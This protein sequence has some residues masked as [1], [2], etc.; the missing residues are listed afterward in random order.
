MRVDLG[1]DRWADFRDPET[2][3]NRERYQF[4]KKRIP[5]AIDTVARSSGVSAGNVGEATAATEI[6]ETVMVDM[7]TGW[8]F[9]LPLPSADPLVFESDGFPFDCYDQ[10]IQACAPLVEALRGKS[11]APT[12]TEGGE[13]DRSGPTSTSNV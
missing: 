11:F 13:I 7:L 10:M 6:A 1:D 2:I 3:T 12:K 4:Q 5:A 9:D 8:S